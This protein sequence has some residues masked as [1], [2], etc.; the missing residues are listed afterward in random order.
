MCPREA[1]FYYIF[2]LHFIAGISIPINALGLYLVFK[3]SQKQSK[4]HYCQLYLQITSFTTE[5]YMSWIAPGYYYFPI[6]AGYNTSEITSSFISTHTSVVFYVLILSFELPSIVLCFQYRNHLAAELS[7]VDRLPLVFTYI[8]T[9]LGHIF[10]F[11]NSFVMSISATTHKEVD[12]Y[13][14][15]NYPECIHLLEIPGFVLYDYDSNR[16]LVFLGAYAVINSVIFGGYLILLATHTIRILN[17]MKVHM[18]PA[19]YKNHIASLFA[20]TLQCVIPVTFLIVPVII[21]LVIFLKNWL[22][23]QELA[24]D[25]MFL[26]TAHSLAATIVMIV[27]NGRYRK[28]IVGKV[29]WQV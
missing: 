7:V 24:T 20:I 8:M 23:M 15:K 16:W 28:D 6:P 17:K 10:P 3:H 29:S 21:I 12:D 11:V 19:T 27:C 2:T 25:T 1:Q 14:Q 22:E 18:S 26:I 9:F 13:L 4:Y 5:L